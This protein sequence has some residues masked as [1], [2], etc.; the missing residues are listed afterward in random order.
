MSDHLLQERLLLAPP[1]EPVGGKTWWRGLPRELEPLGDDGANPQRSPLMLFEDGEPLGPAHSGHADI[2]AHGGGRISHWGEGLYFS[3]SDGSDPN[4]NGRSYG[5]GRATPG[6]PV[7][8]LAPFEA[9]GG[10]AFWAP[11]GPEAGEADGDG[12]RRSRLELYEDGVRLGPRHSL[13]HDVRTLGGGRHLHW[14]QGLSFSTSDN[15]DPNRN[16]RAY[17]VEPGAPTWRVLEMGGCHMHD[18]V[19]SVHDRGLADALW[20]AS[21]AT[22]TPRE[23]L[24]LARQALDEVT[25]PERFQPL[26]LPSKPGAIDQLRAAVSGDLDL[27][28][29]EVSGN[30]DILLGETVLIRNEVAEQFMNPLKAAMPEANVSILRWHTQGLMRCHEGGRELG[31]QAVLGFIE[32]TPFDTPLNREMLLHAR[33]VRRSRDELRDDLVALRGRVG[34]RRF[35]LVSAPN[36]YTPDGRSVSWGPNLL[37]DMVSIAEEIGAP[38]IEVDRLVAQHGVPF[39]VCEDMH[40]LTPDFLSLLGDEVL[41]RL[42]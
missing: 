40:H 19:E 37:R 35:V 21:T 42:D 16:G 11:L 6:G 18:A 15:S 7:K 14:A 39:S 3:T 36:V 26:A 28:V 4:T 30:T 33:G 34:A 25:A 41:K 1:F 8:L 22:Y 13:V 5:I 38:L 10:H 32:G 12:G 27:L 20:R 31:A 9:Q 17:R 23:A 2:E 24:W 29:V